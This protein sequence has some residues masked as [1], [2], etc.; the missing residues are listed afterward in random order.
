LSTEFYQAKVGTGKHLTDRTFDTTIDSLLSR[1]QKP[2]RYIG[3]EVHSIRKDPDTVDVRVALAFPDV[4]ELGMSYSGFQILYH[5]LNRRPN[6]AAERVYAPWPDM[7]EV[8]REAGV[9]LF[10]LE[11]RTPLREFDILGFTLQYELHFTNILQMLELGGVPLRAEAR[12]ASDPLVIAGGPCAFNPE[13]IADFLDAVVLGDGEEI[14]VAIANRVAQGKAAGESRLEL[15]YGLAE[16]PGVYIPRFYQPEYD[17]NGQLT[18][19]HRTS[20]RV[21]DTVTAQVLTELSDDNYPDAP[22]VPSMETAHSRFSLEVMRGCTQG[23]RYCSAGFIYRPVRERKVE[24]L[25]RQA[26]EQAERLGYEEISLT[27]LSTTDY[28]QLPT[29]MDAMQREF[30]KAG[31]ST[32]FS[33][34]SL[35]PD[36][37]TEQMADF[38]GG[39]KKSGVTL[40]CEAGTDRLRRVINKDITEAGVLQSVR[41]AF[42]RGYQT[43]KLYFMIGLPTETDEDLLAIPE[44][45]L[46]IWKVG[47]DA[48]ARPNINVSIGPFAP[49]SWTPFQWEAQDTLEEF[50][51]KISVIRQAMKGFPP[52]IRMKWRDPR[53][54]LLEGT[55]GKADRRVAPV[56]EAVYRRGARFDGWSDYFDPD[57]WDECFAAAGIQPRQYVAAQTHDDCLPWDHLKKGVTK[58]YLIAEHKQALQEALTADCREARCTLCGVMDI[59]RCTINDV[60]RYNRKAPVPLALESSGEPMVAPMDESLHFPADHAG[61]RMR[62]WF[63]KEGRV[64]HIGHL[65]LMQIILRAVRRA[66]VPLEMT[67]GYRPHPKTSFGP[68]LTTGYCGNGEMLDLYLRTGALPADIQA[69][70]NAQF[71]EGLAVT[72]LEE[73]PRPAPA[74]TTQ[75]VAADYSI[76]LEGLDLPWLEQSWL[77]QRIQAT[78]DAET[79]FITRPRKGRRLDIRPFIKVFT[80]SPDMGSLQLQVLF[81]NG[82]TVKVE[83]VLSQALQQSADTFRAWRITRTGLHL[84]EASL[85]AEA[86]DAPQAAVS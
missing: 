37:F 68:P 72:A 5:L 11:T 40:A 33:F 62:V 15:L 55:L 13:P 61:R 63:Y 35:R 8:L 43:I 83:E 24:N 84:Q 12:E 49:K 56:I 21:P 2:G 23:C 26:R 28:S 73:V 1:V 45:A 59:K 82:R 47:K 17:A 34:P 66:R 52:F 36:R 25:V 64:R 81:D 46:N 44:L 22:V 85:P 65:D 39:G 16:V 27:S 79:L 54:S 38:A 18:G 4:Y 9:P 19:T 71:P 60:R 77:E 76:S 7:E 74:I 20:D 29:L 78:L 14:S 30:T 70:V 32:T 58:D 86:A 48:G 53:V 6:V 67:Q 69:A 75:V 10:S 80:V 41:N 42:S 57:L 3:G 31:L 50:Q 51:R